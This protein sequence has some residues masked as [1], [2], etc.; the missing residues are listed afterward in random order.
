MILIVVV[1]NARLAK[2]ALLLH[3]L[4]V[5]F[6]QIGGR[7]IRKLGRCLVVS[8]HHRDLAL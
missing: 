2:F 3:L 6:G 8:M 7:L 4:R 5:V 1:T